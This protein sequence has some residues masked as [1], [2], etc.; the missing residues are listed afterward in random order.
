MESVAHSLSFSFHFREL[1]ILEDPPF[2]HA[3]RK[4]YAAL[5]QRLSLLRL[6]A[7]IQQYAHA[8]QHHEQT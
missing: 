1:N 2:A 6:L 3:C 5:T 8:G 4:D 7:H